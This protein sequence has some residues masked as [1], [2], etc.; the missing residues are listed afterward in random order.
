MRA[1]THAGALLF[2][3]TRARGSP[4]PSSSREEG[5]HR[6][7]HARASPVPLETPWVMYAHVLSGRGS[8][9]RNDYGTVAT[10]A[11]VQDFWRVVQ[12]VP[13]VA[14]L[15]GSG[16]AVLDHRRHTVGGFS[17]FRAGVAPEWEDAQ[18]VCG[19]EWYRR[20]PAGTSPSHLD[21]VWRDALLALVGE[22]WEGCTGARIVNRQA[23]NKITQKLEVWFDKPVARESLRAHR[24]LPT[25]GDDA[26][27]GWV[28][29][30]HAS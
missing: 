15:A 16:H 10:F 2:F 21:R 18:N 24:T 14:Q 28:W 22:Q 1:L 25:L 5:A 23:G 30:N 17:V 27:G 12:N 8:S 4:S 19:G 13:T 7:A 3:L 26:D 11:T 20:F 29:M 6:M 9:Y